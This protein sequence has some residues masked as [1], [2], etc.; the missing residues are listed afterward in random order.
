MKKFLKKIN[1][2]TTCDLLREK[3]QTPVKRRFKT[4]LTA[5]SLQMLCNVFTSAS[6]S[7]LNAFHSRN[8]KRRKKRG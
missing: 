6:S 7:Q 1:K 8:E 5:F 4:Q 2:K 3:G